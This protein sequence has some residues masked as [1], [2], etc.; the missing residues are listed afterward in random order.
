MIY[1]LSIKFCCLVCCLQCCSCIVC[2]GASAHQHLVW[3][4]FELIVLQHHMVTE[5]EASVFNTTCKGLILIQV[6]N[7]FFDNWN[8]SFT[9]MAVGAAGVCWWILLVQS[10]HS[11]VRRGSVWEYPSLVG[12]SGFIEPLNQSDAFDPSHWTNFFKV[13]VVPPFLTTLTNY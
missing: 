4:I 6:N 3:P 7:H 1:C 5:A 9:A 13:F 11:F 10:W 8:G 12:Q 2:L